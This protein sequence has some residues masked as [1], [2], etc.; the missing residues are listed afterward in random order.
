[1]STDRHLS[2]VAEAQLHA[3]HVV[4]GGNR[5]IWA[6]A[7]PLIRRALDPWM[8]SRIEP[9]RYP[10][11]RTSPWRWNNQSGVEPEHILG[12]SKSFF[13]HQHPGTSRFF[14]PPVAILISIIYHMR[15]CMFY[16]IPLFNIWYTPMDCIPILG[17]KPCDNI[18]I[19]SY[20][21]GANYISP[22][23]EPLPDFICFSFFCF[24][25]NIRGSIL[26][27]YYPTTSERWV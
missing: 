22:V 26:P 18:P 3:Q 19:S 4:R 16:F 10:R 11:H 24:N 20:N 1:M 6:S 12:I 2:T 17:I 21:P 9:Q 25:K 15:T 23:L 27:I 13:L 7:H 14:P 5:S 8:P